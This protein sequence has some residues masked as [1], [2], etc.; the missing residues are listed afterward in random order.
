MSAADIKSKKKA[1]CGRPAS[2]R[3]SPSV[4]AAFQEWGKTYF[5]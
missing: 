4:G 1:V 3:H 2:T 5:V